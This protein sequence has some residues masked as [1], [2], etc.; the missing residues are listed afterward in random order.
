MWRDKLKFHDSFW[1]MSDWTREKISDFRG[2]SSRFHPN[3][4][5]EHIE[6]VFSQ[7]WGAMR[8][9]VCRSR[10]RSSFGQHRC[11][12]WAGLKPQPLRNSNKHDRVWCPN[13]HASQINMFGSDAPTAMHF[14]QT[15]SGLMPQPPFIPNKYRRVWCPNRHSFQINMFGSDAPT[16]IH[17]K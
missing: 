16:A 17:F 9:G 8:S 2:S 10:P 1:I 13:R 6:E 3:R 11:W 12:T 15:W 5:Y 14:R 4:F 7:P